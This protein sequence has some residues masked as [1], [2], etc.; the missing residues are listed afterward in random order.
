MDVFLTVRQM[1]GCIW[2]KRQ[3]QVIILRML[4]GCMIYMGTY[5][6]GVLIGMENIPAVL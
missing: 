1:G 4:G 2:K 3:W 6:N 5:L